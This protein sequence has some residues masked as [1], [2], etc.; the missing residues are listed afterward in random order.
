M[1]PQTCVVVPKEG[2]YDVYSATQWM[3]SV[4]IAVAGCLNVP[5]NM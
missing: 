1:E 4:Q 3:D 5:E 2:N